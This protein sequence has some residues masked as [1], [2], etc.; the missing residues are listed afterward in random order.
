MSNKPLKVAQT[1]PDENGDY[2]TYY[3]MYSPERDR[4]CLDIHFTG[5]LDSAF[6]Q[7]LI[8]SFIDDC[9]EVNQDWFN[10]VDISTDQVLH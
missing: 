5:E 2:V 9:Q 6:L 10:F 4:F 8:L 7:G 3:V 1:L